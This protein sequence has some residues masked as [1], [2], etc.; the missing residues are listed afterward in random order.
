MKEK[1]LKLIQRKLLALE[2]FEYQNRLYWTSFSG[3]I[4]YLD[5]HVYWEK[6][7]RLEKYFQDRAPSEQRSLILENMS[8]GAKRLEEDID[9][10]QII[11]EETFSDFGGNVKCWK[12]SNYP[13]ELDGKDLT[14]I[15]KERKNTL[16]SAREEDEWRTERNDWVY[17]LAEAEKNK[18]RKELVGIEE[19]IEPKQKK[20]GWRRSIWH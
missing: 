1:D 8:I 11:V 10:S 19:D 16:S 5:L 14:P 18:L 17:N 12:I 20:K 2:Y 6:R 13:P 9:L 4:L 15:S 7:H 3:S